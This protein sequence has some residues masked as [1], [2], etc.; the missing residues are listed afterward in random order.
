LTARD[1]PWLLFLAR[2][3]HGSGTPRRSCWARGCRWSPFAGSGPG[4]R[5]LAWLRARL[6]AI[7]A[8]SRELHRHVIR[9]RTC[10]RA[11]CVMTR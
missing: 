3:W 8:F 9:S 5:H 7:S 1:R 4:S 6:R 2:K 10:D 11:S